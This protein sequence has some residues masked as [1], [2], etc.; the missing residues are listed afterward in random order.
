MDEITIPE[1]PTRLGEEVF[2]ARRDATDRNRYQVFGSG[3]SPWGY[4]EVHYC[5]EGCPTNYKDR[6]YRYAEQIRVL[7]HRGERIDCV[8]SYTSALAD[9]LWKAAT[10][11]PLE[12]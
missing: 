11:I 1:V 5:D 2:T 7:D 9:L 4:L 8:S 12:D 3:L 10:T 6:G